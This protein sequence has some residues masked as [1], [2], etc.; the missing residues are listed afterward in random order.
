PDRPAPVYEY[1]TQQLVK[2]K[3]QGFTIN[4][5]AAWYL[6][7]GIAGILIGALVFGGIW[8]V[9]YNTA[10]SLQNMPVF[11][12]LFCV[13]GASVFVAFIPTLVRTGPEG[14]KAL[15]FEAL[16]LPCILIFIAT[17][18]GKITRKI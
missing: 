18:P 9:L 4:H 6:N 8:V 5:A 2:D 14:Y 17:L 11:V 1:Y 7:F 12:R 3:R 16:L 10:Q 15:I 13:L